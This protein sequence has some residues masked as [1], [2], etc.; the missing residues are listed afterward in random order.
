MLEAIAE[1]SATSVNQDNVPV[2]QVAVSVAPHQQK[3]VQLNIP[4]F[5]SLPGTEFY[6]N[7]FAT[8]ANLLLMLETRMVVPS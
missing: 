2:L 1:V 4:Q 8:R 7:V 3:D 6:L 5:K